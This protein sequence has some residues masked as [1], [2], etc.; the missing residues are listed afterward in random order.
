MPVSSYSHAP[1]R[2][3]ILIPFW[4]LQLGFEL[5]MIIL[6]LLPVNCLSR[7]VDEDR[8]IYGADTYALSNAEHMYPIFSNPPLG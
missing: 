5:F 6:L 7:K 3:V 2:K 4:A 1:W 8:N